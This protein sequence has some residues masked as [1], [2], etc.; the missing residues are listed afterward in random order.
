M[1]IRLARAGPGRP[2]KFGRP[3][4][5]V[6]VTLPEDV[7]AALKRLDDDVSR[8][9]VRIALPLAADVMP[10]APAELSKHGDTA[11][12]VIRP[13]PAIERMTGVTLVPLPDGRALISL[14]DAMTIYEFELAL[15]DVLDDGD[16]ERTDVSAIRAILDILKSARQAANITLQPAPDH[17]PAVHAPPPRPPSA[18]LIF[19]ANISA[20]ASNIPKKIS[21]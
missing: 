6:T 17:R 5:A 21:R 10:H 8:A 14:D 9:I 7:V 20:L 1:A 11:V 18:G 3:A 19:I 15:R 4:R 2:Q 16:I 13:V 12:I